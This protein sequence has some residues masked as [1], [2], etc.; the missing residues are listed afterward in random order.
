MY[1]VITVVLS[2]IISDRV[3]SGA[4]NASLAYIV[5]DSYQEI[6][7]TVM[8]EMNRGATLLNAKG[9]YTGS[10]KPVLMIAGATRES[11]RLKEIVY[12]VDP[13]AFMIITDANEVRGEGFLK[14]TR[15]EL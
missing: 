10:E 6:G 5:S 12:S 1:A 4:R 8:R 2:G 7:S 11:V 9:M 15:E 14:F 3:I 13:L